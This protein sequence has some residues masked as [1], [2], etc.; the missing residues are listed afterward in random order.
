[1]AALVLHCCARALSS[2]SERGL[3]FAVVHGLLIV[4][5]SLVAEHG[6]PARRLS[7]CSTWA[8]QLW[9]AGSRAQAQQL[10]GTGSVAPRHMG[11]S[12]S[13]A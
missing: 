1:M 13:R 11:S 6:F 4:V 9:I 10:W 5:A 3:L 7:C 12:R 8:Q 2:C